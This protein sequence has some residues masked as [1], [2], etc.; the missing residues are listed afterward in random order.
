M[1]SLVVK[2]L[3]PPVKY[4]PRPVAPQLSRA[5]IKAV[6]AQW[7]EWSGLPA[8]DQL[9]ATL[10]VDPDITDEVLITKGSAVSPR[11]DRAKTI[12]ASYYWPM[13]SHASLRRAFLGVTA[14]SGLAQFEGPR[15]LS[16]VCITSFR[17]VTSVSTAPAAGRV[18]RRIG[19]T[20]S[21]ASARI[22]EQNSTRN[23]SA[24][25]QE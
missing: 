24:A 11:P 19:L 5:E 2:D 18:C 6:A 17:T 10:R 22:A 3:R 15:L 20:G 8:Q 16:C 7:S 14:D 21:A 12:T 23:R 1:K 25:S 9:A 4:K 13:Q